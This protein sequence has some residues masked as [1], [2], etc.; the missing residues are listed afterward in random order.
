MHPQSSAEKPHTER[1]AYQK[2]YRDNIFARASRLYPWLRRPGFQIVSRTVAWTYAVTQ[3]VIRRV[4]RGNLSL[5][6]KE[7]FT[8]ADAVKTF[9]N[10]GA[11]I[12]DYVAAGAMPAE[13]AA[14]LCA[15]FTGRTHLDAALAGEKGFILATGHYGFFELGVIVMH[16]LGR[17][18]TI[19]TLPEP[20]PALTDWRA[21]WRRKWGAETI[22]V[23]A[24]PFSSLQVIRTLEK[25]Q[26][27]AMLVDRPIGERTLP[28]DL[29]NGR[30][31]F[32][33][34]PAVLAWMTGCP[35]LPTVISRQP[36]GRYHITTKP[37]ITIRRVPHDER[38]AEIERCTREIA[39]SLFEE[40][41][42]DPLQW[43]Q[44]VPVGL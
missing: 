22:P 11:T 33:L 29:P 20:T 19:V 6:R 17:P 39:A 14:A 32:S 43:Y 26:G 16:D 18:M 44:F 40:I 30:V 37:G 15:G 38:D 8:E 7:P 34:S 3:P 1:W 42:R 41:C 12:A 5:L 23:G 9:V 13:K 36:G 21:N 2:L 31:P 28:I 4:V 24:D 27:L 10:Y 25:R 35:I